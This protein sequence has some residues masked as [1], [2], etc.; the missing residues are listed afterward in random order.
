ML[1]RA[2]GEKLSCTECIWE[3][4][5]LC[6]HLK[7]HSFHSNSRLWEVISAAEYTLPCTIASTSTQD[8]PAQA[9]LQLIAHYFSYATQ[10]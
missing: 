5:A 7:E 6:L 10:G 2:Y 1:K 9:F 4:C 8:V 3:G